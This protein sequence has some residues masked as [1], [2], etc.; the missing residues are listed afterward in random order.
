MRTFC[1]VLGAPHRQQTGE[2]CVRPTPP[3]ATIADQKGSVQAG[4]VFTGHV[5]AARRH[6]DERSREGRQLGTT[7]QLA[8][9]QKYSAICTSFLLKP[10]FW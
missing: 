9:A 5:H 1:V 6:A 3:W 8:A 10:H 7:H 4:R 2:A